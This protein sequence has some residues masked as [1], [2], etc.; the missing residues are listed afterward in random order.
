MALFKETQRTTA[1]NDRMAANISQS[2]ADFTCPVCCDIF[3]DPV[4]LLCG[5]SFCKH[6]LQ[7]WWRQSRLQ[8]CPV[9]K[10]IFPM[11]QLITGLKKSP[12]FYFYFVFSYPVFFFFYL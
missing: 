10:E 9:C 6:C 8:A 5:H 1:E 7:E 4:L 2:E 3:K 12:V 11:A